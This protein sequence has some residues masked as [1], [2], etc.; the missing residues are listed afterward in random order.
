MGHALGL[1]V[2]AVEGWLGLVGSYTDDAE[3]PFP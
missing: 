2:P 3:I 1:E